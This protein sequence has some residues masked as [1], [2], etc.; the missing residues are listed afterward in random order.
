MANL[1]DLKK[2]RDD[3]AS[4]LLESYRIKLLEKLHKMYNINTTAHAPTRF[5]SMNWKRSK[6][7]RRRQAEDEHNITKYLEDAVYSLDNHP[8][9]HSILSVDERNRFK[10]MGFELAGEYIHSLI[11]S[12]EPNEAPQPSTQQPYGD[13]DYDFNFTSKHIH[14]VTHPSTITIYVN[15][16]NTTKSVITSPPRYYRQRH[17]KF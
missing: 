11:N 17:T 7:N 10:D 16:L 9:L 2:E 6:Q 12:L 1:D 3:Y 8:I 15:D 5:R 14:L 4:H 13:K